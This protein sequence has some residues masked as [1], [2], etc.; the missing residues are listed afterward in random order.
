MLKCRLE[1]HLG[2]KKLSICHQRGMRIGCHAEPRRAGAVVRYSRNCWR[3]VLVIVCDTMQLS[4]HRGRVDKWRAGFT[5][6]RLYG[7]RLYG[8]TSRMNRPT[9]VCH[10]PTITHLMRAD[11]KISSTLIRTR[12]ETLMRGD[13]NRAGKCLRLSVIQGNIPTP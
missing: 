4:S 6:F 2:K 12:N 10:F 11:D 8:K 3:D 1:C 9:L 7:L 5:S 13:Q